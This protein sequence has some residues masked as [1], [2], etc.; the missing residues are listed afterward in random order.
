MHGSRTIAMC[1]GCI[2]VTTIASTST[3]FVV[4]LW[5]D[6]RIRFSYLHLLSICSVLNTMFKT[7]T[8]WVAQLGRFTDHS[9]FQTFS[10]LPPVTYAF[11]PFRRCVSH[12]LLYLITY[13]RLLR[14]Y[15]HMW[16]EWLS[17]HEAAMGSVQAQEREGCIS[18]SDA[19]GIAMYRTSRTVEECAEDG[20]SGTTGVLVFQPVRVGVISTWVLKISYSA[21]AE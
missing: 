13:S 18:V 19:Q 20:N 6:R 5:A 3:M 15:I 14:S 9:R 8:R 1:H 12:F 7:V 16:L 2:L 10:S 21:Y 11:I 4:I 17:T